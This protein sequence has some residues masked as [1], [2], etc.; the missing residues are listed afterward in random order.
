VQPVSSTWIRPPESSSEPA[1]TMTVAGYAQN[2]SGG[3]QLGWRDVTVKWSMERRELP[4]D[5]SRGRHVVQH[6]SFSEPVP[7][8]PGVREL[9]WSP[10]P[11]PYL[12]RRDWD[13]ATKA[14]R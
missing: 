3:V 13:T 10:I 4:T 8:F 6:D 14:R 11:D 1:N 9:R 7:H 5:S 2:G 12:H